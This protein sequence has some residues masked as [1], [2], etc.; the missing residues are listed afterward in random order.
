MENLK[1]EYIY[2]DYEYSFKNS[3]DSKDFVELI[4]MIHMHFIKETVETFILKFNDYEIIKD[5]ID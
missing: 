5:F 3:D 4:E 1:E 2:N